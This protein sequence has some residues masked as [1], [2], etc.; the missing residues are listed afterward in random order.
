M[1]I[2]EINLKPIHQKN[3]DLNICN[4]MTASNNSWWRCWDMIKNSKAAT[5]P[6][7]RSVMNFSLEQT[8]HV[9]YR[10]GGNNVTMSCNHLNIGQKKIQLDVLLNLW[11][12]S[13]KKCVQISPSHT[14]LQASCILHFQLPL[15]QC[16][17]TEN[18]DLCA[19]WQAG[20]KMLWCYTKPYIKKETV[21]AHTERTWSI[22]A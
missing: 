11:T 22:K 18:C 3:G 6:R 14:P 1:I 4:S 7:S 13:G 19:F 20:S 21:A 8:C 10:P 16:L 12:V 9:Q 5:K 17:Y 2:L 15:Q